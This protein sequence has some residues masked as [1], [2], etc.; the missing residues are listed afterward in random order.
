VL[1][2][3]NG[4]VKGVAT[5][6][7]GVSRDG[8]PQ[9]SF[10]P[11][12]ELRGKYTLIGEGARGSLSKQLIAKFGLDKGHEPQKYGIGIKELW[13]VAPEK[14]Q[15]GLVQHSFGWPLGNACGGGS[16]MYHYGDNLVVG[17]L[18]RAPELREPVSVAVRRIPALQDPSAH[19]RCVRRRQ[20]HRS[21]A[22]ARSPKAAG[23]RCRS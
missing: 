21:M 16:F 20:A 1:Y 18:R 5:G 8:K 10:V 3:D 15:R 7:M 4:A 9:D 6:D 13:Q 11:G 14:H 23:S 12:M 22:R 17:R 19:P 2:D